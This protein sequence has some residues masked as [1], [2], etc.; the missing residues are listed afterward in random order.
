MQLRSQLF[1]QVCNSV[2]SSWALD[3]QSN[4]SKEELGFE[5][6][7]KIG[8]RVSLAVG[9]FSIVVAM[10]LAN[11]GVKS[12]YEWF[13][14]FMGLVLGILSEPLFLEHLPKWLTHLVQL[15]HCAASAV[16]VYIKYFVPCWTGN[17]LELF[18]YLSCSFTGSW[19]SGKHHLEKY[20]R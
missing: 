18:H 5:K 19:N 3:I 7:T 1:L 16:M 8:Q 20:K 17:D 13:N 11:G 14:G 12:A 10:V 2:A 9:I 4:L 6:E 15:L